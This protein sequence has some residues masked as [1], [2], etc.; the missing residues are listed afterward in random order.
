M[1][2]IGIL[3]QYS[4][5]FEESGGE[6][7]A[8]WCPVHA[9]Q[10]PSASIHRS[11]GH[12]YCHRCG[13]DGKGDLAKLLLLSHDP[14]KGA[15][16]SYQQLKKAVREF[17]GDEVST[18]IGSNKVQEW[19]D[20]FDFSSELFTE[21]TQ[22][23]LS[24]DDVINAK[25][26]MKPGRHPRIVIPIFD[27][28]NN[29]ISARYYSPGA[30]RNK[31]TS[32]TGGRARCL[33]PIDQL[34]YETIVICGG[35]LK[36]LVGASRLNKHDIGCISTTLG[37]GKWDSEF[38]PFFKKKE[39]YICL[40]IDEAGVDAAKRLARLL[41]AEGVDV[42]GVIEL[43]L[44][45]DRFPKGDLNDYF[46]PAVDATDEQF[47]ETMLRSKANPLFEPADKQGKSVHYL[48]RHAAP[49][50]HIDLPRVFDSDKK[51]YPVSTDC[52][53]TA[54]DSASQ[55]S[56]PKKVEVTCSQSEKCCADCPLFGRKSDLR[57]Y[58]YN[59]EDTLRISIDHPTLDVGIRA[60][61][62][63][64]KGCKSFDFEEIEGSNKVE[65]VVQA[66]NQNNLYTAEFFGVKDPE[67]LEGREVFL[68]GR[69]VSEKARGVLHFAVTEAR[70][71]TKLHEIGT[72]SDAAVKRCKAF[73]AADINNP[74][75][76][77]DKLEEIYLDLSSNV[78]QIFNRPLL[79]MVEDL[80]YFSPL[81][82]QAERRL[83]GWLQVLVVGD[84]AQ[85]KSQVAD[86]LLEWYGA[87]TKVDAKVCTDVGLI[88]GAVQHGDK[89][90]VTFGELAKNDRGLLVLEELK[91]MDPERFAKLTEVR[92]SGKAKVTK[93]ASRESAART[94]LVCL[95]NP[96][97]SWE[98]D[99][100]SYG[101]EI[102]SHVVPQ[103]EDLRRFDLCYLVSKGTLDSSPTTAEALASRETHRSLLGW[104]WGIEEVK[105]TKRVLD[106][107][108]YRAGQL[109]DQFACNIPLVDPGSTK[110][111]LLKLACAIA[112]RTFAADGDQNLVVTPS[113]VVAAQ[114]LMW[115]LY[116]D[117]P[118]DLG[119]YAALR[120]EQERPIDPDTLTCLVNMDAH[121]LKMIQHSRVFNV[122][123]IQDWG[124]I[125]SSGD[126][127]VVIQ[128]LLKQNII[129]PIGKGQYK[130]SLAF[131]KVYTE[132][133]SDGVRST[134]G[135][136]LRGLNR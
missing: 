113:H 95:S 26:G 63:V 23:G 54:V 7:L 60:Y 126:A 112:A 109:I 2:V 5:K 90:V 75:L 134:A 110:T 94:R 47:I 13:D 48:K 37:E 20:A 117:E 119:R 80:V 115:D 82:I 17:T 65:A 123:D 92:T 1:D 73:Q 39:V 120:R 104:A 6:E 3:R 77:R 4:V 34:K 76:I 41:K 72:L 108:E 28:D 69:T 53:V 16:P 130:K 96:R 15:R 105:L 101:C 19:V 31:M 93:V 21:L 51:G 124:G 44:D 52:Y 99:D 79:H 132:H 33:Y 74:A 97:S 118:M 9:D 18:S 11:T 131:K 81:Y 88:G 12:W 107:A 66:K 42:T 129:V 71:K 83:H 114:K 89:W 29:C 91:G 70:K 55:R 98:V 61:E 43:P 8:I 24:R 135:D 87:G 86:S 111:K 125:P 84:T 10:N 59:D 50:E 122:S 25:L 22:R 58:D 32:M 40:D 121:L 103:P 30:T 102:V 45:K 64:P 62:G 46:G 27:V 68:R 106:E 57:E 127:R 85:G 35:E 38:S 67:V 14:K 136:V 128:T 116:E 56:L 78:T 133:F 100:Y 36:A 49:L